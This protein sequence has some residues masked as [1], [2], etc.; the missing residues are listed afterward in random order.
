MRTP[1]LMMAVATVQAIISICSAVLRPYMPYQS[2]A[3]FNLGDGYCLRIWT[4]DDWFDIDQ[5]CPLYYYSVSHGPREVVPPSNMGEVC[6]QDA[7][8]EIVFADHGQ[9]ACV[10]TAEPVPFMGNAIVFDLRTQQT[11]PYHAYHNHAGHEVP[12]ERW[13]ER[14]QKLVDENP[15]I[16]RLRE[17][18]IW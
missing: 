6:G 16:P 18:A 7:R 2:V 9:L 10:Y 11:W 15:G 5:Q 17:L 1:R 4:Y 8:F 3:S 14:F 12:K 13:L